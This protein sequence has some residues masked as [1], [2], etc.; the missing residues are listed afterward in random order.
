MSSTHNTRL[1]HIIICDFIILII[2]WKSVQIIKLLISCHS[3]MQFMR[4]LRLSQGYYD[5]CLL[6]CDSTQLCRQVPIYQTTQDHNPA[7]LDLQTPRPHSI[8]A[9]TGGLKVQHRA[10][11]VSGQK[12]SCN[13]LT[14]AAK[15]CS[16]HWIGCWVGPILDMDIL[17][18]TKP[19]APTRNWNMV[20][21]WLNLY[22]PTMLSQLPHSSQNSDEICTSILHIQI[23]TGYD[24]PWNEQFYIQCFC[25]ALTMQKTYKFCSDASNKDNEVAA[26]WSSK[27]ANK[28][29]EINTHKPTPTNKQ[30]IWLMRN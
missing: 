30:C 27:Q 2:I 1:L 28:Q 5:Y 19:P 22:I 23:V 26:R 21:Q 25:N 14:P 6:G 18:K 4:D 15:A 16:T 9:E 24:S 17:E 3:K 12:S 20:P 29:T 7:D 10:F 8:Y 13:C 11:P